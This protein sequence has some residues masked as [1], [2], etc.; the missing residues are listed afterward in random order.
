MVGRHRVLRVVLEEIRQELKVLGAVVIRLD[1]PSQHLHRRRVPV[2]VPTRVL[3]VVPVVPVLVRVPVLS[4][5][6]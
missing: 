1:P 4:R 5:N 2:R 3:V 6:R